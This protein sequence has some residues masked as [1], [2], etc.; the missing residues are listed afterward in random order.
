[1]VIQLYENEP[2]LLDGVIRWVWM[3]HFAATVSI[4]VSCVGVRVLLSQFPAEQ[5]TAFTG[6]PRHP[7]PWYNL[8]LQVHICASCQYASTACGELSRTNK[9]C[10]C[11][12]NRRMVGLGNF[13]ARN[14]GWKWENKNREKEKRLSFKHCKIERPPLRHHLSRTSNSDMENNSWPCWCLFLCTEALGLVLFVANGKKSISKD[15]VPLT[16]FLKKNQRCQYCWVGRDGITRKDHCYWLTSAAVL[17]EQNNATL[18]PRSF[19]I[20]SVDWATKSATQ[21]NPHTIT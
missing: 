15:W 14:A 16:S 11:L 19:G 4:V 1:M 6:L 9:H 2:S 3:G 7:Q 20:V 8:W 13:C 12:Q 21:I 5:W 18:C 10:S 17:A